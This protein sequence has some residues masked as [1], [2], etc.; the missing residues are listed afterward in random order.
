MSINVLIE[1]TMKQAEIKE[2]SKQELQEKLVELKN[3]LAGLRLAH[4]V[5]PLDNPLQLPKVRKTIARLAT[6]L[7]KRELR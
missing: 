1:K 3:Q 5:T 4:E 7:T 6:E 2:L